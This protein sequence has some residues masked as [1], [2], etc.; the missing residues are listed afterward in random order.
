MSQLQRDHSKT[1]QRS[2]PLQFSWLTA[3]VAEILAEDGGLLCSLGE[4]VLLQ[5]LPLSDDAVMMVRLRRIVM[6]RRARG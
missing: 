3:E 5:E 2:L 1:A 6:V 4:T